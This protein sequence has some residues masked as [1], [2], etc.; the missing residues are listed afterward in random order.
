MS[1]SSI[2]DQAPY[3][4]DH[5]LTLAY[6][7]ATLLDEEGLEALCPSYI[8]LSEVET[9]YRDDSLLGAGAVKEVHRSYDSRTKRWVAMARLRSDRGPEFYDLFVH[10]AWLTSSLN[11]PNIIKVYDTGVDS[12]GR[13]FFTMDLKGNT[14]LADLAK[15]SAQTP[16]RDLLEVFVKVCDA[17]A[18]AHSN[19][20]LHLDLKPEN[21]QTDS[22]GEV[23]V[24][25]WGLGKVIG[26]R[27]DG[28]AN[29]PNSLAPHD[30]MT[31]VGQVKGTPGFLAPE[32]TGTGLEKDARSDI[33]S[34]GCILH[35]LLTGSSPFDGTTEKI[36]TRTREAE[37]VP[38]SL[39]Y[40]HLYI[41]ESLEAVIMKA[42]SLIP[43]ERYQS[44]SA[45]KNEI[46]QFLGGYSTQAEQSG[47]F[48]EIRLFFSRHR[49][50]CLI[51][52]L[53]MLTLATLSVFF[54]RR[55]D[56]EAF[57]ANQI[58]QQADLHESE[59]SSI[60]ANYQSLVT[61]SEQS[62]EELAHKLALSANSLKNLGIFERPTMA[63]AQAQNLTATALALDPTCEEARFQ[64]FSLN[65]LTLNF[66]E[67]LTFPPPADHIH[68]RYLSFAEAFPDFSFSRHN[69]PTPN[70]LAAFFREA[71]LINSEC[72]P[73]MERVLS[74]DLATRKNN[75]S[76]DRILEAF[77]TYLNP[78]TNIST[79]YD[80]KKSSYSLSANHDPCLLVPLRTGSSGKCVLHFL[81]IRTLNLATTGAFSLSELE[82]LPIETLNIRDCK[83]IAL[84]QTVSLPRLRE[85]LIRP[86]QKNKE[87]LLRRLIQSPQPFDVVISSQ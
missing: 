34:L 49:T 65:C 29:I 76:N 48:R 84:S 72:A 56:R 78:G 39:R 68:Y 59:A 45:L 26:E 79:T 74:Y 2:V 19:N 63:V 36:L 22:F 21:I 40:P 60:Q 13:P 10:E 71:P 67:A 58:Q 80:R 51:A 47:F 46:N 1:L 62:N 43:D 70:Q 8:E 16:L 57:A 15:P 32:Q 23:L 35:F 5:R 12:N 81:P 85:I 75:S 6:D 66:H 25:D 82:N 73:L 24:C 28:E 33:F 31:L 64:Q 41:P 38:P 4:P 55:L 14:S 54:M 18:Y 53:S 9:R 77:L 7:E 37:F 87:A 83:E 42:T 69:R 27:E 17:I 3:Q 61:Q 20:S 86:S 50:P 44:A 52:I 30:N 11:H